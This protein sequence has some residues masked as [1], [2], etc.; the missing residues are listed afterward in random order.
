MA[1]STISPT[2]C[3]I[4]GMSTRG[5]RGRAVPISRAD[6]AT[7]TPMSAMRSRSTVMWMA[8]DT[9]RRSAARGW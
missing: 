5:F 8:E 7:F 4:R 2:S 6:S 1:P 3:P 9:V